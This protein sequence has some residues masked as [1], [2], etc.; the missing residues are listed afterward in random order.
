M[1]VVGVIA[2]K[3][4]LHPLPA[5]GLPARHAANLVHPAVQVHHLCAACP[6]VKPVY[7]LGYQQVNMPQL[8]QG[9]ERTVRHIWPGVAYHRPAQQ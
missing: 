5:G 9:R 8:F 1:A 6:L 2:Q 4:L 3:L 7:V